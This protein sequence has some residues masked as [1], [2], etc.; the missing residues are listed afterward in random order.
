MN[1]DYRR[2]FEDGTFKSSIIQNKVRDIQ[3]ASQMHK[4]TH[5]CFKYCTPGWGCV[6]C[7]HNYPYSNDGTTRVDVPVIIS[8]HDRKKRRRVNVLPQRNNTWINPTFFDP[9]LT[10]AHVGNHD[11]QYISNTVGAAEYAASY[12]GKQEKPDFKLV[13]NLVYK[14]L[15]A[16]RA[17][18]SD[19][20][21]LKCV[22]KAILDSTPVGSVEAMYVLL[23]LQFVKKSRTIEN[24]NALHR[25]SMSKAVELDINK[26]NAMDTDEEP[27]KKGLNSHY[28]KRKAYESLSKY[29]WNTY[30]ECHITFYSMLA[31]FTCTSVG[32]E[33]PGKK[34][35]PK[36]SL[37]K[38]ND[39]G[40][41]VEDDETI[42]SISSTSNQK[43]LVDGVIYTRRKKQAVINMCPYIAVNVNDPTS[44]YAT[45]LLHVPWPVGGEDSIVNDPSEAV[46]A[47]DNLRKKDFGLPKYVVPF[48]ERVDKSQRLFAPNNHESRHDNDDSSEYNDDDESVIIGNPGQEDTV[49]LNFEE[50]DSTNVSIH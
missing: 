33:V 31:N 32:K 29:M 17:N 12:I 11:C 19:L 48:L 3:L 38:L 8:G 15:N 9:L 7:R 21:R 44:C 35:I 36:P 37:I 46:V 39:S 30:N 45:L 43:F 20:H 2:S 25:T 6:L 26:V 16:Q 47:L 49:I 14:S 23:G 40:N 34:T 4:H 13:C 5:S 41:I 27:V 42:S 24:V 50:L 1:I 28:G 10:L 22:G 18:N